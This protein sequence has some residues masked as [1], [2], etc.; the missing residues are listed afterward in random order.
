MLR[1]R[2]TKIELKVE[3]KEELDNALA[4][5]DSDVVMGNPSGQP[6]GSRGLSKEARIGFENRFNQGQQ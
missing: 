3:D 6:L 2:P 5:K 4:K 1:R